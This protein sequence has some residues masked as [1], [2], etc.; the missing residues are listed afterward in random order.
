MP[1][2]V[3]RWTTN[4]SISTNVPG[5]KS[6]SMR[7]RAV[8]LPAACWRSMRASPPPSTARSFVSASFLSL[9][10]IDMTLHVGEHGGRLAE[11]LT[12][13]DDVDLAA[14]HA[15]LHGG[16]CHSGHDVAE[17][18]GVEGLGDDVAR[19]ELEVL[20]AVG[21]AH[22]LGHHLAAAGELRQGLGAGQLHRLVDLA[23]AHVQG[24]PE[25]EREAEHVVDLVGMVG[26]ARRH[27]R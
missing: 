14:G 25:D 23:G 21:V 9:S 24:A 18:P 12:V 20:V 16:L 6:S 26:A 3:Q 5:S 10:S 19:P 17:E 27:D 2:S 1:K 22:D 7:S 8:S 4:R 11:L 15:A 13:L